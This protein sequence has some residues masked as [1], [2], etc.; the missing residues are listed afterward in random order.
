MVKIRDNVNKI[1]LESFLLEKGF[2]QMNG[3]WK[4]IWTF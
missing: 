1:E 4:K 3:Q 2:Y